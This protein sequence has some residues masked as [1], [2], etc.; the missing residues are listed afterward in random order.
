MW[1]QT[2]H[3]T[4]PLYESLKKHDYPAFA[5]SQ[6]KERQLAAMPPFSFQALV[7][8]EARTQETAQAFLN[9]ASQAAAQQEDTATLLAH[10]TLY[11]A[12]PMS[13][14]R[15][16]N[17]E[18][19]QMLVESPSRAALQRFLNTWQT[20]LH[21]TRSLPECKGVLRWAIDVDPLLI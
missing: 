16:A 18:R 3:P 12:V 4:H 8:A 5:A 1:L 20:V 21:N 7:R 9:L 15:I 2:F 11:P 14:A 19:A 17:I 6:L 13:I 10:L